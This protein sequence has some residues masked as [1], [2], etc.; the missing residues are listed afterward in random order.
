MN[1]CHT[2]MSNLQ[3]DTVPALDMSFTSEKTS[4]AESYARC[5]ESYREFLSLLTKQDC[6]VV[7]RGQL[8]AERAAEEY[9]RLSIWGEQT[10]AFLPDKSR[11][12]LGDTLRKNDTVKRVMHSILAQLSQLLSMGM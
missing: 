11:G 10:R 6:R 3:P 5:M 1:L 2:K 8:K 4:L 7:L 12:S 9:G